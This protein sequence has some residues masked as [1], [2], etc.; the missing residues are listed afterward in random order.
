MGEIVTE[1]ME[2]IVRHLLDSLGEG[3]IFFDSDNRVRWTNE[4]FERMRGKSES[5]SLLGKSI[6]DCHPT[7]DHGRVSQILNDLKTGRETIRYHRVKRSGIVASEREPRYDMF[8]T[9][10]RNGQGEYLGT[11]MILRDIWE[12]RNL[13][14]QVQRSE[15]KYKDLV[16]NVDSG[17]FSLNGKGRITYVNNGLLRMLGYPLNEMN[18][19]MWTELVKPEARAEAERTFNSVLSQ[20]KGKGRSWRPNWY[21]GMGDPFTPL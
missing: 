7:K 19:R 13:Q 15:E 16:E 3:I 8:Y 6:F 12:I 1:T 9:G 10:V 5:G 11:A 17:I 20:Q 21:T 14:D 4:T 2:I 18:N